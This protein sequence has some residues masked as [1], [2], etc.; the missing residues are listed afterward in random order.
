MLCW[1]LLCIDCILNDGHKNHDISSIEKAA[2]VEK[3]WFNDFYKR[4]QELEDKLT[5]NITEMKGHIEYVWDQGNKNKENLIWIFHKVW[6]ILNE[7]ETDLKR[8]IADVIL[9]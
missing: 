7:W 3:S 6:T 2:E 9:I 4:S 5:G 8:R 1:E